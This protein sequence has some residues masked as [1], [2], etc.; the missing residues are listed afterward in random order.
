MGTP[1]FVGY[2][3][4]CIIDPATTATGGHG[5]DAQIY[6]VPNVPQVNRTLRV[7]YNL[8]PKTTMYEE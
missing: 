8:T 3:M 5:C 7:D 1:N 2:S 4:P 6:P